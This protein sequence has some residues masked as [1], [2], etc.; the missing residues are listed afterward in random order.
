MAEKPDTEVQA[1][2]TKKRDQ[3]APPVGR[4]GEPSEC[5][6]L[7]SI[8][9]PFVS[10]A[11]IC[12]LTNIT[13]DTLKEL[14]AIPLS[15]PRYSSIGLVTRTIDGVKICGSRS[16]G[17]MFLPQLILFAVTNKGIDLDRC[18]NDVLGHPHPE[19]PGNVFPTKFTA[20]RKAHII[21][22]PDVIHFALLWGMGDEV[23][24]Y[25]E[26]CLGMDLGARTDTEHLAHC[27]IYLRP[28]LVNHYMKG[29][30]ANKHLKA[31]ISFKE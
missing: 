18:I 25:C 1:Q 20:N 4:V 15:W 31:L 13:L 3:K 26:R 23:K 11:E 21:T 28:L 6:S 17:F 27:S 12:S 10:A 14:A 8:P 16:H 9:N 30:L 29:A 22:I 2:G 19:F 5:Y 24:S 7:V